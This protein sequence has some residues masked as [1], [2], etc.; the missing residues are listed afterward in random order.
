MA[1]KIDAHKLADE[2]RWN[3]YHTRVLA[4]CFII[5]VLDG[6][7]LAVAGT[8]LPSIMAQMGIEPAHAGFMVSSALFGMMFGAIGLGLLADRFGRRIALAICVF[9]F[10]V[11][12]AAAGL[13]ADPVTFAAMRFM[14]GLGIGGAIPIAAAQMTEFAPKKTRGMM[15]TLMCCGYAVGNILAA[16]LGKQLI[17]AYG[18]QWV[19]FAAA[20]PVLLIPFILSSMPESMAFMLARGDDA[21]VRRTLGL[22]RPDQSFAPDQRFATA[23]AKVSAPVA[24]LFKEGRGFSTVMFWIAYVTCLFMLYALSSWLVKLLA[25]AGFSLGSAL[26]FLLIYNVGAIAGAVGGGWLSDRFNIKWVLAFFFLSAGVSLTMLGYGVGPLWLIV[27]LVGASTLG[28]QI[29]AY[30]YV[31]QYYPTAIKGTGLGFASGVGRIG[32]MMA[33]IVIGIIVGMNLPTQ[34]NFLVIAAAGIIG[35]IAVA[36]INHDRSES[37]HTHRTAKPVTRAAV[38]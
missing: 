38:A 22:I 37:G 35:A 18:W 3:G 4:W 34:S 23:G 2:A 21:G 16:L 25:L 20:L 28:T 26:T 8:A 14:A 7:D 36:L 1:E 33:P 13:A 32:A 5:L 11:F 6:Y 9:L 12:T 10:S 27:A 30:A 17:E 15:V 19:F 29:L 31:G 24:A